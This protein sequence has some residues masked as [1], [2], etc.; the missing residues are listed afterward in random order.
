MHIDVTWVTVD[1]VFDSPLA[2]LGFPLL[3]WDGVHSMVL[4][5]QATEIFQAEADQESQ[6]R[7]LIA[8]LTP[9]E[10]KL[11][12]SFLTSLTDWLEKKRSSMK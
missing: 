1:A 8:S 5:V 9:E 4:P 10:Q 3:T 2:M 11:R 6:K 7:A 12:K